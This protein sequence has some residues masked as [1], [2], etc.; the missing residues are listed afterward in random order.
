MDFYLHMFALCLL[1]FYNIFE[2]LKYYGLF[3]VLKNT[4]A[5]S[6]DGYMA[7]LPIGVV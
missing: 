4:V 7:H 5:S 6:I 1:L 3:T 2:N